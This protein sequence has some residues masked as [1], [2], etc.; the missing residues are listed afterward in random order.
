MVSGY[1]RAS[2]ASGRRSPGLGS[3]PAGRTGCTRRQPG[4]PGGPQA[5][6][7]DVEV[8]PVEDPVGQAGHVPAP[9]EPRE[10]PHEGVHVLRRHQRDAVHHVPGAGAGRGDRAGQLAHLVH[11]QVRAPLA[12]T[13]HQVGGPPRRG[14]AE[15]PHRRGPQALLGRRVL[16]QLGVDLPPHRL[17]L[18]PARADRPDGEPALLDHRRQLR[19]G[20]DDDLVAR[21]PRRA[22]QRQQREEVPVRGPGGDEDAHAAEPGPG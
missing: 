6:R 1:G 3:P 7:D 22:G 21:P 12:R 18:G 4:W 9:A 16:G 19:A 20:R 8:G 15:E 13:R 5:R 2:R 10:G 14:G 17:G 11:H